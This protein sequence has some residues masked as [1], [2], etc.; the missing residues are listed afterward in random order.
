MFLVQV[1]SWTFSVYI[2]DLS[3]GLVRRG[4]ARFCLWFDVNGRN[5]HDD[6]FKWCIKSEIETEEADN[7]AFPASISFLFL[8]SSKLQE[9]SFPFIPSSVFY[10]H[11]L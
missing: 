7:L 1:K 5:D 11:S 2:S 10:H 3:R 4:A 8:T 9:F 6:Y